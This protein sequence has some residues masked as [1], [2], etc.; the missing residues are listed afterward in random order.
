MDFKSFISNHY[1]KESTDF[2]VDHESLQDILI[3]ACKKINL[4]LHK[5]GDNL[6]IDFANESKNKALNKRYLEDSETDEQHKERKER[7]KKE[8]HYV[9]VARLTYFQNKNSFRFEIENGWDTLDYSNGQF[10]YMMKSL[11]SKDMSKNYN[12]YIDWTLANK[13]VKAVAEV[14]KGDESTTYPL[15]IRKLIKQ[16]D[17]DV[18]DYGNNRVKVSFEKD[19]DSIQFLKKLVQQENYTVN[20]NGSVSKGKLTAT[21]MVSKTSKE[22]FVVI[23]Y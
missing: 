18:S 7:L 21:A 11:K 5:D 3:K 13:F 9:I 14:L 15:A 2:K 20:D 6:Y 10:D 12:D 1:L 23:T 17:I 19:G 4:P 8:K 22:K 16:Y